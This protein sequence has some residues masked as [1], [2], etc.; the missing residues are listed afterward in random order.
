MI[1]NILN[2]KQIIDDKSKPIIIYTEENSR[3]LGFF[4]DKNSK[5]CNFPTFF[6]GNQDHLLNV[7][8]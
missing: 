4:C 5:E 3:L 6:L 2:H 8:V 1:Q 7:H